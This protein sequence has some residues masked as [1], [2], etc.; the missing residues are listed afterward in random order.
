MQIID[1]SLTVNMAA[2]DAATGL[3]AKQFEALRARFAS[4]RQRS[5]MLAEPLSDEDCCVQSMPD[6]SPI[7][8]HLAHASWFFETFILEPYMPDFQPF[9]AAFRVLFNSYYNGVGEKHPRAQ[10]GLLTRPPLAQV[11]AYRHH[12]DAQMG[13]LLA[14]AS[15]EQ[16]ACFAEVLSVLELGLQHEQQHQELMLTD[17]KHLLSCNPLQPAYVAAPP[18]FVRPGMEV[19]QDVTQV[20]PPLALDWLSFEPGLLQIGHAGDGFCFDNEM[21]Q[22]RQFVEGFAMACRLVTNGEYLAFVEAGGYCDPA[23]WL[24]EGWDW[25]RAQQLQHPLYWSHDPAQGWQEFTLHGTQTLALQQPLTPMSLISRPQPMRIGPGYGCQPRQSGNMRLA[26][27]TWHL[28]RP[29]I[30]PH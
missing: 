5:L 16:W 15:S 2:C 29:C 30:R 23:L 11:I 26:A 27:S 8:W 19:P 1:P 21:P 25:V 4:V 13:A 24:S 28:V 17:V 3:L 22:H 7:K 9:L 12:V 6:A 20:P 18:A 10:R 14:R